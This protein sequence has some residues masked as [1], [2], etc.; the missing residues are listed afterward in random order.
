MR[1][2]THNDP[3]MPKGF[4]RKNPGRIPK[5]RRPA[6]YYTSHSDERHLWQRGR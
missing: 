1:H 6:I 2:G 5:V 3:V 4:R